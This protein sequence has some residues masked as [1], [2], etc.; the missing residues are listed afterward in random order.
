MKFD[1]Q[2]R[3]YPTIQVGNS[4]VDGET[5]EVSGKQIKTASYE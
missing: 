3:A 2:A 5:A 1:S 4:R